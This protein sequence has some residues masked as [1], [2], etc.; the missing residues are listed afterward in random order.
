M[1]CKLLVTS[2]ENEILTSLKITNKLEDILIEGDDC[3]Y[4]IFTEGG[5]GLGK[6]SLLLEIRK[7]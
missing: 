5:L 7:V 6:T 4:F 1:C 3:K 2:E